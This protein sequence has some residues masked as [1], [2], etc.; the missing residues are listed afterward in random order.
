ME[1]S[2]LLRERLHLLRATVT[3]EASVGI[4]FIFV[5]CH[6]TKATRSTL[7]G[8][9][10][11]KMCSDRREN[12]YC[13]QKKPEG[14]SS[15]MFNVGTAAKCCEFKRYVLRLNTMLREL[16]EIRAGYASY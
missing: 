3:S 14:T 11:G 13:G 7:T 10:L 12:H 8:I 2:H 5:S 15:G 9:F 1:S 4:I 6:V 16:S